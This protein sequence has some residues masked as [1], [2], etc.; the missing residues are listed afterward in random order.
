MFSLKRNI[1]ETRT[2]CE[3]EAGVPI[4]VKVKT[5][6]FYSDKGLMVLSKDD[7]I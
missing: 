4:G 1:K 2:I 5:F 7:D 3:N 6:A